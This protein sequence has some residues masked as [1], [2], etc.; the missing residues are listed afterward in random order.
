MNKKLGL[1][2]IHGMGE[3]KTTYYAGLEESVKKR[4]GQKIWEDIK[5]Y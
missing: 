3:T 1:L 4:L 5:Y 2:T